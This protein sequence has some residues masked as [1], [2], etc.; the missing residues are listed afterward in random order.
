MAW[1]QR[2]LL[3]VFLVIFVIILQIL[4]NLNANNNSK[5]VN[6]AVR[7]RFYA[8]NRDYKNSQQYLSHRLIFW[9]L[10]F[11]FKFCDK[12]FLHSPP[13][14][15]LFVGSLWSMAICVFSRKAELVFGKFWEG[16]FQQTRKVVF[17]F[18]YHQFWSPY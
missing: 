16:H 2:Q 12:H 6:V 11:A 9:Y 17:N 14:R 3:P 13:I 7:G 10:S 18:F 8:F 5:R 1:H 4:Q 15:W